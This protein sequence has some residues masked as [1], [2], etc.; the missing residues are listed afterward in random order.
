MKIAVLGAG[1]WGTSLARLLA[2]KGYQVALWTYEPELVEE[3]KKTSI[4]TWYLDGFTL[5]EN[6]EANNSIPEVLQDAEMVVSV[7]PSH[8]IR[9]VLGQCAPHLPKTCPVVCCSKGIEIGT[10]KLMSEVLEE[11][12]PDHPRDKFAFLSGPSF[13]KEVA[14]EHPTAVVIAG[15]D[16]E[17]MEKVQETFRTSFFMTFT[18]HDVL[19]VEVGGALKNV[20]AIATGI[21][22]GLGYGNN[23]RAA[24]ITRGLYELI[25][26]G[27]IYGAEPMTFAGLAG[28]GDLVLTCTGGL[29][30]NRQVGIQLGKGKSLKEILE[31]MNMVAEG[32]KT[33]KAVY[34]LAEKHQISAPI[35]KAIY[36]I[37]YEDKAPSLAVQELTALPLS[38]E[39]RAL[40]ADPAAQ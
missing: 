35:C 5:P 36:E 28:M 39:F 19:G 17:L 6:L 12:L 32:V 15:Y 11:V 20:M 27:Q 24:L 29:S 4:N 23:T 14:Q 8:A 7:T 31:S 16:K 3:I 34:Q 30:R 1:S 37:L 22:D 13:A 10:G 26:V 18:H 25:K 2:R 38:Q 40:F 9:S 33:T 21:V